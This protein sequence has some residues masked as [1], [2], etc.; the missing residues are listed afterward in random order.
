M[1]GVLLV[2]ASPFLGI[3][4]EAC[5][6]FIEG[7]ALSSRDE[8]LERF[9]LP[10]LAGIDRPKL[11]LELGFEQRIFLFFLS[12]YLLSLEIIFSARYALA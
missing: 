11:S 3:A 4:P 12:R 7:G 10:D 6:D 9:P 8:R 5:Q 1:L 2:L